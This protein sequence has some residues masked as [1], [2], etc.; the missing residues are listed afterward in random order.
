MV[1]CKLFDPNSLFRS[2]HCSALGNF[3]FNSMTYVFSPS[4]TRKSGVFSYDVGIFVTFNPISSKKVSIMIS[5]EL[6]FS[7]DVPN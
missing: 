6:G 2:S 3:V 5:S 4:C 7:F 1:L